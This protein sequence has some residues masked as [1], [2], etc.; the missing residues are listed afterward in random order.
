MTKFMVMG[1][2]IHKGNH[3]GYAGVLPDDAKAALNS[4]L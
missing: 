1:R 3:F 4:K 2:K